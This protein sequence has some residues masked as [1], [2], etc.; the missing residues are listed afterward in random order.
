MRAIT[1]L[2]GVCLV[3]SRTNGADTFDPSLLE[4]PTLG[5]GFVEPGKVAKEDKV[6]YEG[7]SGRKG[8]LAIT[9]LE[10]GLA[11]L[12]GVKPL[13]LIVGLNGWRT[14]DNAEFAAAIGSLALG[15]T[16]ELRVL[17][18]T[19]VDSRLTYAKMPVVLS[20]KVPTRKDALLARLILDEDRVSGAKWIRHVHALKS[21]TE[22]TQ[23]KPYF[24]IVNGKATNLRIVFAVVKKAGH[25]PHDI[26]LRA[27]DVYVEYP[28]PFPDV[29]VDFERGAYWVDWS[30]DAKLRKSLIAIA[31]SG[32][33]IV[34]FS[35]RN[36]R[37]VDFELDA[38]D[39]RHITDVLVGYKLHGG[40]IEDSELA[41]YSQQ[42]KQADDQARAMAEGVQLQKW[43]EADPKSPPKK[44]AD[45]AALLESRNRQ[46]AMKLSLAK[47]LIRKEQTA[48]ATKRLKEIIEQHADTPAAKEAEELLKKI[49]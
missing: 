35:D 45:P 20:G 24:Q 26:G 42:I 48:A 33:G 1:W 14:D 11:H 18:A 7:V 19:L 13:D 22:A 30:V 27:N 12:A 36:S 43:S 25:L 28:V 40:E 34:R 21:E 2:L 37:V 17:R 5:I 4:K 8:L 15:E 23:V 39:V 41:W 3:A 32:K 49:Q 46:A 10:G 38:R 9:V 44:V 31:E 29:K 16:C 6:L 47:V